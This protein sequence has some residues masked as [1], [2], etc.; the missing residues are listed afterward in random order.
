MLLAGQLSL[1]KFSQDIFSFFHHSP[2]HFNAK[3]IARIA[4]FGGAFCLSQKTATCD[5]L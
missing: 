3:S 4:S 1:D 5:A 2:I